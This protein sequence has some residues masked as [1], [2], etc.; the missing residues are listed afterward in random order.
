M[1]RFDPRLRTIKSGKPMSQSRL[2]VVLSIASMMT[3][4]VSA[5]DAT[6]K[7]DQ[8]NQKDSQ[9]SKEPTKPQAPPI[10][11]LLPP[12]DVT[13]TVAQARAHPDVVD[14]SKKLQR[15]VTANRAWWNQYI[16]DNANKKPLPYH[17]KFGITEEEYK[18]LLSAGQLM[19]LVKVGENDLKVKWTEDTIELTI[20]GAN[21]KVQPLVF[22]LKK[23]S[24]K[25]PMTTMGNATQRDSGKEGGLLGHHRSH[26][27]EATLGDPKTGAY[28]RVTFVLGRISRTGSTFLQYD[29]KKMK[30]NKPELNFSALMFIEK[31]K[32]R[33]D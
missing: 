9:A 20:V 30:D 11:A 10:G 13:A 19:R 31:H 18:K 24:V 28:T 1:R 22:D 23:G 4:A 7:Q 27:W 26:T 33:R 17:E 2:F 3:C 12:K 8:S 15:A 5:Q 6:E 16:K 25:T 29:V 21:E 14:I 32:L